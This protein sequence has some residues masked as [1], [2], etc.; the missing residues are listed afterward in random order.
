MQCRRLQLLLVLMSQLTRCMHCVA[1]LP[2]SSLCSNRLQDEIDNVNT[3]DIA[4]LRDPE[5]DADRVRGD[6]KW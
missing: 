4:S 1:A 5:A 6:P 3:V 2:P